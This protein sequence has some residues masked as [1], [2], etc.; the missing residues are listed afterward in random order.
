MKKQM[1]CPYRLHV[2]QVTDTT[3]QYGEEGQ[4]IHCRHKLIEIQ[5][6]TPCMGKLCGAWCFGRCRKSK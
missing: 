4:E 6:A 1:V 5:N 2:E 3:R